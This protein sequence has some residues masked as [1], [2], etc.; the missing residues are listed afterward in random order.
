MEKLTLLH[1]WLPVTFSLLAVY[2][3]ALTV[4]LYRCKMI[5][6]TLLWKSI[7]RYAELYLC[8]FDNSVPK[9]YRAS[10]CCLIAASLGIWFLNTDSLFVVF[11]L[12]IKLVEHVHVHYFH[13]TPDSRLLHFTYHASMPMLSLGLVATII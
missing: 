4:G 11:W 10:Y 12:V 3:A 9:Y 6:D 8:E 2:F 1:G 5:G 7:N 13:P